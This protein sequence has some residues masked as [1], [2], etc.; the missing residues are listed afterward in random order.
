MQNLDI[1]DDVDAVGPADDD[2][3]AVLDDDIILPLARVDRHVDA[4]PSIDLVVIGAAGDVLRG[5]GYALLEHGACLVRLRHV[6]CTSGQ[7]WYRL[8]R[9]QN[10]TDIPPLI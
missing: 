5:H 4:R 8:H 2:E 3:A 10:A 9:E 6:G 7:K 1:G